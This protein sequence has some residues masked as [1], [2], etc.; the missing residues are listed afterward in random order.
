MTEFANSPQVVT[1]DL[2]AYNPSG[3]TGTMYT[4]SGEELDH[5]LFTGTSA[6]VTFAPGE[7]VA[8]TFPAAAR[9]QRR[10]EDPAG[11]HSL[12]IANH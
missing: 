9:L 2:S 6:Q 4:M 12:P 5:Q 11:P 10:R 7:T 3:G 8:F 1:I